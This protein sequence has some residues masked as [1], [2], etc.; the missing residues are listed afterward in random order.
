[1]NKKADI[2]R[3]ELDRIA[4]DNGGVLWP[5]K[6]VE[7]ARPESSPLHSRFEWDNSEAAER[8]RLIQARQLINITVNVVGEGAD[9][10]R[11]WVSLKP[12]REEAGGY[13][14]M[15]AVLSDT[16]LRVQLLDDALKDMEAFANKYRHLQELAEVFAAMSRT[17]KRRKAA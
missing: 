5:K 7:A 10:E 3:K 15:I 11:M 9:E 2:I 4:R 6:V 17:K 14:S 12:D 13:R 1:M 16:D 8:Y